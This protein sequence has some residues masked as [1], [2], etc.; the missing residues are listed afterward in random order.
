MMN[1]EKNNI[2]DIPTILKNYISII[3]PEIMNNLLLESNPSCSTML[4]KLKS[5]CQFI[6][7][8]LKEEIYNEYIYK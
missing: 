6:K 3:Q 8:T 1:P 5:I 7:K 2:I 4:I